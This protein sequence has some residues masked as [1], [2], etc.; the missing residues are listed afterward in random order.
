MVLL[1]IIPMKNG[2]FIGGIP[3]IFR[4]TCPIHSLRK[5]RD[6]VVSDP[7]QRRRS[8]S[9]TPNLGRLEKRLTVVVE[10]SVYGEL[11]GGYG[12]IYISN[13]VLFD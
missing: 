2:Y 10:S 6:P 3:N 9:P 5:K 1:I 4:Q 12:K 11:L 8:A 7:R 13:L